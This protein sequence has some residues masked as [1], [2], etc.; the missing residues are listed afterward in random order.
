MEQQPP[1]HFS[2]SGQ[3]DSTKR[4]KNNLDEK[5]AVTELL[6]SILRKE[7]SVVRKS[8]SLKLMVCWLTK[9]PQYVFPLL[10]LSL[11][12]TLSCMT[13]VNF[14]QMCFCFKCCHFE[15]LTKIHYVFPDLIYSPTL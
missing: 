3:K 6:H 14:H 9:L 10:P 11:L 15:L 12:L 8:L 7:T 13:I 2:R 5:D 1:R 4:N